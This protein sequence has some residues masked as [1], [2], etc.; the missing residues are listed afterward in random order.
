MAVGVELGPA[1]EMVNDGRDD[2]IVHAATDE[3]GHPLGIRTGNGLHAGKCLELGYAGRNRQW[4][5]PQL[6]R[7]R[8]E[9]FLDACNTDDGEHFTDLFGGVGAVM[10]VVHK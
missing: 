9:E 6:R 5:G 7:D 3:M 8:S 4:F 2:M 10:A 1:G